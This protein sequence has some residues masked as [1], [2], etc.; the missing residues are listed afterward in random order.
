MG[1][2]DEKEKE[3]RFG[4]TK[5]K[6]EAELRGREMRKKGEKSCLM[7]VERSREVGMRR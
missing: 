3:E 1:E 6:K 4:V 7:Q 2:K 5:M